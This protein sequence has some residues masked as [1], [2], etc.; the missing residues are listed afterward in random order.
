LAKGSSHDSKALQQ[1]IL[2]ADLQGAFLHVTNSKTASYIGM[3]GIVVE[4]TQDL[5]LLMGCDDR[6]R[7]IVKR[8]TVF[9]CAVNEHTKA[10]LHGNF[11]VGRQTAQAL[12]NETAPQ[13]QQ[14]QRATVGSSESV[15]ALHPPTYTHAL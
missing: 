6:I 4:E 13:Q 14:Q 1:R 8:G 15:A 5:F 3:R 2:T 12:L 9:A 11:M 7:R 10:H